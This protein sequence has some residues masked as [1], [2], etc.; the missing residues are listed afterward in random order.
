MARSYC[1]VCDHCKQHTAA[2]DAGETV[3]GMSR[4]PFGWVTIEQELGVMTPTYCSLKC[5]N[6]AAYPMLSVQKKRE[7]SG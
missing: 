3:N 4:P 2:W 5:A 7:H 1:W 6:E